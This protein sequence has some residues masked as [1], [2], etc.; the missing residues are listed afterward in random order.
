[1]VPESVENVSASTKQLKDYYKE[2]MTQSYAEQ[3]SESGGLGIAQVL[4]EQMKR[5]YGL[6]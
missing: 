6:E 4:Y 2:Q 3:A 1:M 5:N